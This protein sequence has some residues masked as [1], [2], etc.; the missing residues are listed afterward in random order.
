MTTKVTTVMGG[1]LHVYIYY[2]LAGLPAGGR[3]QVGPFPSGLEVC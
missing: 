1:L 2:V 3:W